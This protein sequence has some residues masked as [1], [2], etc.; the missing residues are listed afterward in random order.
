MQLLKQEHIAGATIKNTDVQNNCDMGENNSIKECFLKTVKNLLLAH[1]PTLNFQGESKGKYK[2]KPPPLVPAP[3]LFISIG[4]PLFSS[5]FH[6][7]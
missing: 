3:E 4:F 7:N 6:N 2:E 5:S 1:M